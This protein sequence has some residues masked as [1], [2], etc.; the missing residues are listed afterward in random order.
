ME[1]STV[2]GGWITR[3]K[4]VFAVLWTIVVVALIAWAVVGGVLAVA[5]G[6]AFRAKDQISEQAEVPGP[7][8]AFEPMPE[9]FARR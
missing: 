8:E 4:D 7:R 2:R 6:G 3:H 1:T 5:V 9:A